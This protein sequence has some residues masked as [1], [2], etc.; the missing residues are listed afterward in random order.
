[1]QVGI[2]SALEKANSGFKEQRKDR[3]LEAKRREFLGKGGIYREYSAK[4]L[5]IVR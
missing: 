3:V 1:M 2:F 5:H 4:R